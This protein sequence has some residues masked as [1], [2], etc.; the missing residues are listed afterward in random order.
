MKK[1]LL[2]CLCSMF[3][4]ILS[5]CS[6]D[7]NAPTAP[8]TEASEFEPQLVVPVGEENARIAFVIDDTGSM[9][10]E[11]STVQDALRENVVP[12]FIDA[13]YQPRWD[14]LTFKDE[15]TN[16][17]PTYDSDVADAW[18]GGLI[19]SGGGDCPEVSMDALFEAATALD[20]GVLNNAEAER[21]I[22]L[23]T[24]ASPKGFTVADR[25][26]L[27][28]SLQEFGISVHIILT[29]DCG[30]VED[31]VGPYETIAEETDGHFFNL[32]KPDASDPASVEAFY[33]VVSFI[34]ADIA[35]ERPEVTLEYTESF[36]D[37]SGKRFFGKFTVEN[38][39]DE[40]VTNWKGY[41]KFDGTMRGAFGATLTRLEGTDQ[42]VALPSSFNM[43]IPAGGKRVFGIN[44]ISS[45]EDENP[46]NV[47]IYVIE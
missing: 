26:E 6:A 4:V 18:I 3:L 19:A 38:D 21:H 15:V 34:L 1:W 46:D 14:R 17:G 28:S 44:A 40:A 43:T 24:D 5:A 27:I 45:G 37:S 30:V 11:I 36:R 12:A 20:N 29:G 35:N 32:P 13:G 41:F 33:E 8:E 7:Q 16:H 39:S 31:A 9:A 22:F 10:E 42:Y 47:A 23:A 25:D 2:I